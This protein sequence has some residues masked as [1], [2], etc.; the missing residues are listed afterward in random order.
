[1]SKR[2]NNPILD[3]YQ[4]KQDN[5]DDL[6]V[7]PSSASPTKII[8]DQSIRKVLKNYSYQKN[9]EKTFNWLYYNGKKGGAFC[10][11]YETFLSSNHSA[12]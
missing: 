4:K 1:M 10:K 11:V 2:K 12:L 5:V 7:I 6:P 3:M 8:G 9:W